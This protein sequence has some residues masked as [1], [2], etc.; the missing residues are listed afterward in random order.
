VNSCEWPLNHLEFDLCMV[1]AKSHLGKSI[2][3]INSQICTH[4][5]LMHLEQGKT[6][7]SSVSS[8]A[9]PNYLVGSRLSTA[10]SDVI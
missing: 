9:D 4:N 6:S 8:A 2:H 5:K 3:S 7:L 1:F 10:S